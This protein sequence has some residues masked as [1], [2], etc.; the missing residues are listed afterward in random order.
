MEVEQVLVYDFFFMPCH[1]FIA[2]ISTLFDEK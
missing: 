1:L 2:G